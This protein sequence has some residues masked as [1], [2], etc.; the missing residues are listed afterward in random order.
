MISSSLLEEI[1]PTFH[2]PGMRNVVVRIVMTALTRK[3]AECADMWHTENP[4]F[5]LD[6]RALL[7]LA[8]SVTDEV[9]KLS[10]KYI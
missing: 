4:F 3:K 7:N 1:S 2:F 10:Q 5:S 6:V 8:H 9:G